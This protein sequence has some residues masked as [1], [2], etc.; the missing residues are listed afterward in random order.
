MNSEKIL[1]ACKVGNEN[2][3][4]MIVSLNISPIRH[5]VVDYF[6]SDDIISICNLNHLHI[7]MYAIQSVLYDLRW[8]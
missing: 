3:V 5:F 7:L 2:Y 8:C 6:V 4:K 1:L